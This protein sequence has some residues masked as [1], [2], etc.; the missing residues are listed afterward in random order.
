[1]GVIYCLTFPNGKKYIG[2]TKQRLETRLKQHAIQ[3]C[4]K[5]VHNAI[6][7]YKTYNCDILLEV[8]NIDLDYYEEK[9]IKEY[10]TIV[11]N[12][13][14]IREGGKQ[15]GFCEETRKQMS[16]S[17]KGKKKSEEKKTK[18]KK[19]KNLCVSKTCVATIV[20]KLLI[21]IWIVI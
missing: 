12:G 9:M 13:Y 11:P 10:K 17:H 7:K 15:S 5:A 21:C 1:M 6:C 8:N 20:T 4:C 19:N 18:L 3:K 14:N 2:Q 16:Y